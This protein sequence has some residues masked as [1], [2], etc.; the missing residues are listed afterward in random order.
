MRAFLFPGQGS[1]KVGMAKDLYNE[2]PLAREIMDE[3]NNL[4]GFSLTDIMFNGPEEVLKESKNTQPAILLHSYVV[5]NLIKDK[6]GFDATAGHSLGEYTALLAAGVISFADA[7]HLVR[8]RGELMSGAGQEREGTMA[9]IIGLEKGD[10]ESIVEDCREEGIIVIANYNEP[11]QFVV[12]GEKT[13]VMKAVKLAK[14]KGGRGIP[15][16]VSGAFHSPLMET[17]TEPFSKVLTR[18]EFKKPGKSFYAN[19]TGNKENEPEKIRELLSRQITSPVRWT[20]TIKNM[21]EDGVHEYVEL[22]P[23]NVLTKLVQKIS[24][25]VQAYNISNAEDVRRFLDA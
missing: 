7:L 11:R 5:Y 2:F 24:S 9:A 10:V 4:L 12:S 14:E 16:R 13:P 1:Q 6:L 22:G 18:V 25:D 3:A 8:F 15:L 23:G 20:D 21:I 17:A 19:V